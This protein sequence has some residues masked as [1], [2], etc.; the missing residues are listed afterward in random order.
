MDTNGFLWE[1]VLN[2]YIA[3]KQIAMYEQAAGRTYRII[4]SIQ[5]LKSLRNNIQNW[6]ESSN[7][8][9]VDHILFSHLTGQIND[10]IS[11]YVQIA[12][13]DGF[14]VR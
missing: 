8:S 2:Y 13:G 5:D 6:L 12:R 1:T 10:T 3:I 7:V 11:N 9:Q 4:A 14:D